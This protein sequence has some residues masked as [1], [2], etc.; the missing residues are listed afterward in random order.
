MMARDGRLVDF[1]AAGP[2]WNHLRWRLFGDERWS[3]RCCKRMFDAVLAASHALGLSAADA[4]LRETVFFSPEEATAV[5]EEARRHR[6][7]KKGEG[8]KH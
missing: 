7:W 4:D 3:D 1:Y 5:L 6:W 8:R 2:G